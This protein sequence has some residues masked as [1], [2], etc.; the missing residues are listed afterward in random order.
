MFLNEIHLTAYVPRFMRGIQSMH[1]ETQKRRGANCKQTL[2]IN[3]G[4]LGKKNW[5]TTKRH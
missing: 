3:Q 1:I 5:G 4:T 2:V